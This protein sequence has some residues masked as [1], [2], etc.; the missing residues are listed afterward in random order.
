MYEHKRFDDKAATWDDDLIADLDEDLEG[1]YHAEEVDFAG[2]HGFDRH[3]LAEQLTDA[4][5]AEVSSIDATTTLNGD[6]EFGVFLCT[7]TKGA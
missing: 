2:H 3:R 6:R 4:G 1:A 7:A 5:F